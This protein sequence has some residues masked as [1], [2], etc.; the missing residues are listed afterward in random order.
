MIKT[1]TALFSLRKSKDYFFIFLLEILKTIT[2]NN[3][4]KN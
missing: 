1:P 3:L 4:R 2:I